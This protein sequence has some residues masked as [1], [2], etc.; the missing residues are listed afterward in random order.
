[1][2]IGLT[3][4]APRI[5]LTPMPHAFNPTLD[6]ARKT[7]SPSEGIT[8]STRPPKRLTGMPCSLCGTQPAFR[9]VGKLYF[10]EA[11]TPEA[12]AAAAK[13]AGKRS[14]EAIANWRKRGDF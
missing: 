10:C 1:M 8:F 7:K 2:T 13:E 9:T 3:F 14:A 12:Y 4:P 6:P 5:S 11:H